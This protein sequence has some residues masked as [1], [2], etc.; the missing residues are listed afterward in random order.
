MSGFNFDNILAAVLDAAA[1]YEFESFVLGFE[2]TPESREGR[3][4]EEY[5]R[6]K[7]EVGTELCHRWPG[8]RVEF[9]TP[10]LRID[11]TQKLVVQLRAAPLFVAGRYRKL[12]RSIPA[13]RWNH[14][15]CK[16]RG[17]EGCEYTGALCGPSIQD[18]LSGP[19]LAATGGEETFFHGLGREDTDARMLGDGRPFVVEVQEPRRRNADFAE[20][21]RA[22]SASGVGSCSVFA[23]HV[24]PRRA[25]K[26]VKEAGADKTYRAWIELDREPPENTAELA[27][28]LAGTTLEQFSPARVMH[29]RG[30]ETIRH[31]RIVSS[32]WL[33][34][35]D[36]LWVWEICAESGTYIKELVSGDDLASEDGESTSP[37]TRP[38]LAEILGVRAKCTFLDVLEIH[39]R[40]PWETTDE[41]TT[42][43]TREPP[44]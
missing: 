37:R 33:G 27:G 24:V 36:D 39:W 34:K 10:D 14:L 40:G 38:S 2:R 7:A 32:R 19:L 31:K 16:G 43:T 29:R 6:L 21:F 23:P 12:S 35:I 4:A 5:R 13:S 8:R 3:G 17:C 9:E 20:I 26:M 15:P 44:G 25:V 11:V 28:A 30:R 42:E 18:H 41:A 22:A 1:D